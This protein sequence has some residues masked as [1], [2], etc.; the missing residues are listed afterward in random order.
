MQLN[1]LVIRVLMCVIKYIAMS[2]LE[3]TGAI[4][5]FNWYPPQATW[6]PHIP[7]VQCSRLCLKR[8]EGRVGHTHLHLCTHHFI[9]YARVHSCIYMCV[10]CLIVSGIVHFVSYGRFEN[11]SV[12]PNYKPHISHDTNAFCLLNSNV[13][14]DANAT[15]PMHF[16]PA[17]TLNKL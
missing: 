6:A 4:H 3:N 7:S 9:V 5:H 1:L 13:L 10:L 8:G 14:G 11:S 16:V 12:A 15:R 2:Q 17:I